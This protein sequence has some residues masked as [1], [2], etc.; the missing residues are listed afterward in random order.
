LLE[1]AADRQQA[2][3]LELISAEMREAFV[4]GFGSIRGLPMLQGLHLADAEIFDPSW[5]SGSDR[6]ETIQAIH[7]GS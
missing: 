6:A 4:H 1:S 5:R 7:S 2:Q 3:L